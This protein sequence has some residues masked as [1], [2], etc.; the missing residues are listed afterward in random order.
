MTAAAVVLYLWP[1]ASIPNQAGG[2]RIC[3]R[4]C[5][6]SKY[7]VRMRALRITNDISKWYE[8]TQVALTSKFVFVLVAVLPYMLRLLPVPKQYK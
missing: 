1:I 3:H 7:I 8:T 4:V 6:L 5:G 2:H